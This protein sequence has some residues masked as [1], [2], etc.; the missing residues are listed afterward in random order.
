MSETCP[1]CGNDI[2]QNA[3]VCAPC[4]AYKSEK[5]FTTSD[6]QAIFLFSGTWLFFGFCPLLVGIFADYPRIKE[7]VI[8][9]LVG[10]VVTYVYYRL[11]R[12]LFR[13]SKIPVWKRKF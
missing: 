13:D 11:M 12:K 5:G 2:K 1:Y 10:C 7:R 6:N 3:F 4:G 9:I 8:Y